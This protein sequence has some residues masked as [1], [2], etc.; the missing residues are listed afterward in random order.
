M[1]ENTRDLPG[2][3]SKF[4]DRTKRY[5]AELENTDKNKK[6]AER[7]KEVSYITSYVV[8]EK[9]IYYDSATEMKKKKSVLFCWLKAV[10]A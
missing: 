10:K 5:G 7:L 6:L 2:W 4:C 9:E 3:Y 1:N 8:Q